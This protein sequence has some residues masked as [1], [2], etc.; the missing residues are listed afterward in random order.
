MKVI[1]G[2]IDRATAEGAGAVRGGE[3][4]GTREAQGEEG[5]WCWGT[6]PGVRNSAECSWPLPV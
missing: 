6:C 5:D 4:P 1:Q 2:N 3:V